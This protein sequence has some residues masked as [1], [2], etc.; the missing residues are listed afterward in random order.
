[1]S[2]TLPLDQQHLGMPP[3]MMNFSDSDQI[4]NNADGSDAL[5]EGDAFEAVLSE[6]DNTRTSDLGLTDGFSPHP[7]TVVNMPGPTITRKSTRLLKVQGFNMSVLSMAMKRARE[8]HLEEEPTKGNPLL[9]AFPFTR[10][11]NSEI[12]DLFGVYKI[13]L[14]TSES[15]RD[16][17]ISHMQS[18]PRS[19]FEQILEQALSLIKD[20]THSVV[21]DSDLGI[22]CSF[23]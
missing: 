1:M 23:R 7:I 9:A 2:T 20:T 8:K 18:S 17:I 11:T 10:L 22:T 4:L 6:I 15:Q 16:F 14:G 19:S 12:A 5:S 13:S 3:E 21:V